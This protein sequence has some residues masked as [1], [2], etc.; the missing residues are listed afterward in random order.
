MVNATTG[1]VV[2]TVPDVERTIDE[3]S[4]YQLANSTPTFEELGSN[5][6]VLWH[7]TVSALF[8]AGH[9]PDFGWD[10]QV[11][12]GLD[13]G[14]VGT[15]P[16]GIDTQTDL[17]GPN[18]ETENLAADTTV[19]VSAW[20]REAGM[21]RPRNVFV[22][23]PLRRPEPDLLCRFTGAI[24]FTKTGTKPTFENVTLTLEG[25]NA[26][27]GAISWRRPAKDFHALVQGLTVPIADSSHVVVS[28]PARLEVLDTLTGARAP[29]SRAASYW[30]E[31]VGMYKVV[32]FAGDYA[33]GQRSAA[34]TF[35]ACGASGSAVAGH[36]ASQPATVG[37]RVAGMFVWVSATG[38]EA[39]PET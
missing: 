23:R 24:H 33:H 25:F 35:G 37:L 2:S 9:S 17:P 16:Q 8:G 36:P 1:R 34:P 39:E 14:T 7:S 30:C 31:H 38:L 11:L 19:R 29:A 6:Q 20:R 13:I 12:S 32:P 28:A 4:L 26:T 3:H 21:V 27:T 18:G 22:R 10:V 5:A 15:V